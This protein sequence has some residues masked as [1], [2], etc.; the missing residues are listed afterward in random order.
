MAVTIKKVEKWAQKK[1]VAK[2]LKVLPD[3]TE[4][5]V[6]VAIL[7]ALGTTTDER[8]M[9]TTILYLRDPD[10]TVRYTAVESLGNMANG[11]ALEFVRQMWNNEADEN[12]RKK[13]EWAIHEIKAKMVNEEKS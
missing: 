13:A 12:I 1:K 5:E 4:I 3:V 9:H 8:A 6:R 11:R 7:K 2:L 10:P